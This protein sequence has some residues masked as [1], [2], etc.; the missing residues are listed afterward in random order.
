MDINYIKDQ[1]Q[2]IAKVNPKGFTYDFKN[3]TFVKKGFVIAYNDTQ[4]NHDQT[5]LDK[6]I[7]HAIAHDGIV[8]GWLDETDGK[9]YFDSCMIE[10]WRPLAI[11]KGRREN[12][13]AIFDLNKGEEIRL[14]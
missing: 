1:I 2:H 6:V 5:N 11:G 4:H 12:Q 8:C 3:E 13:I 14:T 10:D 9:Y 7:N